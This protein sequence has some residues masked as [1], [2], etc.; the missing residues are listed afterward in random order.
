MAQDSIS[1][2]LAP[3]E[4]TGKQVK[5]LRREGTVP[6]VIHDHGAPS[7]IVQGDYAALFKVWQQAG[8]H[9]PVEL[10]ANGKSYVAL[11]KTAEFDPKKHRLTHVVF[12]AVKANEKVEAEIP[13]E[14]KFA[15]GNEA[16]PAERSGLLVLSQLDALMVKATPSNLPDVLYY[17]AEK[18][19]EVGDHATVA[20]LV[21]PEGVEVE[22]DLNHAIATVY[23]P[24]ALAAANEAAGG[25]AEEVA[26]AEGEEEANEGETEAEPTEEADKDKAEN[27]DSEG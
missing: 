20:D 27:S 23:E 4:V 13:I 17:D 16:S 1:L 6:A 26:P 8:K 11:I 9:H 19:V 7:V 18:L 14:P 3:R 22:V 21:I 12:N 5:H 10:K 15:E 25:D 24:S 2:T